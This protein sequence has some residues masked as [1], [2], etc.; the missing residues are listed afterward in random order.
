MIRTSWIIR[1]VTAVI[2]FTQ[3]LGRRREARAMIAADSAPVETGEAAART[4]W[5]M[6]QVDLL[7][8]VADEGPRLRPDGQDDAARAEFDARVEFVLSLQRRGLVHCS[9]PIAELKRDAM[10]AE[11]TDVVL[12][13]EGRRVLERATASPPPTASAAEGP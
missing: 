13:E 12:T 11:I 6:K 7:R 10:Y 5:E 3:W 9:T 8:R 2:N 4:Q 1:L